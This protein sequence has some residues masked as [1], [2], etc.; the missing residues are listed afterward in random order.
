MAAV[1]AEAGEPA[2]G[3]GAYGGD[4]VDDDERVLG[5]V[6]VEAVV[7]VEE[8]GEIEEIEPPD[9]VGEALGDEEGPEAAMA[10]QDGVERAALGDWGEARLGSVAPRRSLL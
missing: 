10:E 4:G 6:Q 7:V 5:V 9:G 8:L 3:D 1:H 2:A